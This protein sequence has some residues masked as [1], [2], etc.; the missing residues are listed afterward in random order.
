MQQS[1]R[2]VFNAELSISPFNEE[3][4][5]Y[6]DVKVVKGTVAGNKLT[7]Y[8]N[9]KARDLM[10]EGS[11]LLQWLS[12]FSLA[13]DPAVDVLLLDEPDAH[14]HPTLQYEMFRRVAEISRTKLVL[15]ATHSP[16]V[17]RWAPYDEILAFRSDRSPAYLAD[18]N[19]KISLVAGIG[20]TYLP[21]FDAAVRSRK[22]LFVEGDG[23]A[24]VLRR[25]AEL[26]NLNWDQD[27][28]VWPEKNQHQDRVRLTKM[29]A[30]EIDGLS[31]VSIRD[32]DLLSTNAVGQDLL[33]T[34]LVHDRNFKPVTWKRRNV[35][36]YLIHPSII[37]A[38]TGLL[39][40]EVAARMAQEFGLAIAGNFLD[41]LVP[42]ALM[43]VDGKSVLKSFG[44]NWNDVIAHMRRETLP[45]DFLSVL[46]HL[47][48]HEA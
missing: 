14:L 24:L 38:A 46:G 7:Q 35:E 1:L 26:L 36:S 6:I 47:G 9:Y 18:E 21:R 33:Q 23:D 43:D 5:S 41:H 39:E 8:P 12:V 17:I 13:V 3:Y 10:V 27:W 25:A 11:G 34:G 45:Q 16:E 28:V 20:S 29:L 42:P 44:L 19:G 32:R 48:L 30:R 2:N 31:V 15:V 40:Q 22:I 4:H 37:S